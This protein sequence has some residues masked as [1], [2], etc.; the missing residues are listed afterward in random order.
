MRPTIH[1][2][3]SLRGFAALLIVANH[4]TLLMLP[5][6]ATSAKPALIKTG[7][8]G[9]T[10][11]FVLSGFVMYYNYAHRIAANRSE[12]IAQFLCARIA[13]L[14]P[15]LIAYVLFN[16]VL[17]ICR[18]LSNG[19]TSGASLYVATLPLYL[20]GVQSW[21]YAVVQDVNVTVSQYF[22]NPAWS[23][24]TELFFYVLFVPLI[25]MRQQNQ[26]SMSRGLFIVVASIFARAMF[27]VLADSDATQH[28]IAATLGESSSLGVYSWLVYYCPY[29]RCFEFLAG[30]G[31]A[32]M[33]LARKQYASAMAMDRL[34]LLA[35][36][37]AILYIVASFLSEIVFSM[38]RFF[39]NTATHFFYIAAVPP[40]I[41]FLIREQSIA[42]K[43]LSLPLLLFVGDISYSLYFI[44]TLVFPLFRVDPGLNLKEH[45]PMILGRVAV[46]LAISTVLSALVYRTLE[47][48]ARAAIMR[49]L[50]A[51]RAR[52]LEVA[53]G[54]EQHESSSEM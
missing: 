8:L 9:M 21:V 28:W 19:D 27:L 54:I 4:V 13:R 16:F 37:C 38:P 34:G 29:G 5:L 30:M 10:M 48:P 35:G 47:K 25:V 44:H 11:F 52:M 32:E 39:E 41:Y 20:L 3:T 14:Y 24:S 53:R 50:T 33:W 42:S 22:G 15:L 1:P 2:L 26:P 43:L 45:V 40:A 7:I 12:G 46:F 18:S 51:K 6:G 17:N 23:V 36:V 31:I 49:R